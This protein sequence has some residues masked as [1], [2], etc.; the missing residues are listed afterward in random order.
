MPQLNR[1]MLLCAVVGSVRVRWLGEKRG[2]L[3]FA[4]LLRDSYVNKAGERVAKESRFEAVF[5]GTGDLDQ[6]AKSLADAQ[7]VF[8]QGRLRMS[9]RAEGEG[10]KERGQPRYS[11]VVERYEILVAAPPKRTAPERPPQATPAQPERAAPVESEKTPV[12]NS[13]AAR[14]D[15]GAASNEPAPDPGRNIRETIADRRTRPVGS[16][17]LFAATA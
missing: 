13:S 14:E 1:V 2:F 6:V 3:E 11:I 15:T 17:A 4:L 12:C 9:H 16:G 8:V 10:E 7:Q 5:H